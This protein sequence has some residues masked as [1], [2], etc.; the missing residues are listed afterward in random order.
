MYKRVLLKGLFSTVVSAV[1]LLIFCG[2]ARS[3]ALTPLSVPD[4]APAVHYKCLFNHEAAI[5]CTFT[6]D[7][8]PSGTGPEYLASFIEKLKDTDVDAVMFCPTAWRANVFPSEVDPQWKKYQEGQVTE[9]WRGFDYIMKYIHDGGDPV[10]ETLAACRKYGKDF[11][12]SYRMNDAHY[13]TDMDWP[14]HTSFW[15]DHPEYW[16]GDSN[17]SATFKPDEDNVRL[18]NYM[19]PEVRNWYFA[20]LEELCTRYDVDGVELDFQRAPRFFKNSEIEA[21]REVMTG[22]VGRIRELLDQI[23]QQRGKNLKLCV[24]IPETLD[25][26]RRAGLDVEAWDRLQLVDMINVSSY[27]LYSLDLDIE[28]F[29][30][31]IK[32]AKIYAEMLNHINVSRK[33]GVSY[34]ERLRY[35]A[36]EMYR[37]AALNFLSRGA[38]GLSLFNYDYAPNGS[39]QFYT[40]RIE[41][42]GDL[43]KITDTG[44]LKTMSKNYVIVPY[45]ETR[46]MAEYYVPVKDTVEVE[47]VIPDDTAAVHFDK[48]L[49]RVETVQSSTNLN[50]GVWLNGQ[51]L[52]SCEYEGTELFTPVVSNSHGYPAADK[53]KFFTVP[54]ETVI[55]GRNKLE[56]RNLDKAENSCEIFSVEMGFYR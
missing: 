1:F 22:F 37:A 47:V 33:S 15:R 40:K 12:I 42:A 19:L 50:L 29:K 28:D 48:I 14:T 21:G 7:K 9:K 44:Y 5:F 10:A 49:L 3:A 46:L 43:K 27:Y 32:R 8:S 23:G 52:A 16:L 38:D 30:T 41:R 13:I 39:P 56:I 18:H 25:K 34:N 55:C 6:K 11:F 24:R 2:D 31:R 17:I 4:A 20:I 45:R 36:P 53:L 51:A 35:T 26:C 54:R